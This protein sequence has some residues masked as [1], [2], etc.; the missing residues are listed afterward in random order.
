MRTFLALAVDNFEAHF[1]AVSWY[2]QHFE[3]C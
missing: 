1:I 3:A 2:L